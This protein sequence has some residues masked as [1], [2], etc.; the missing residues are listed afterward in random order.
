MLIFLY[1]KSMR[2]LDNWELIKD[3]FKGAALELRDKL[4]IG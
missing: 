4:L 2:K 1:K 3:E